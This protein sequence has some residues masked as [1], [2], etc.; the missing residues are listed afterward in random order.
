MEC[1]YVH[2]KRDLRVA[3]SCAGSHHAGVTAVNELQLGV[4]AR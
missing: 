3:G 1:F 4:N 2:G